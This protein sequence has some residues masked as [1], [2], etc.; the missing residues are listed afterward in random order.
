MVFGALSSHIRRLLIARGFADGGVRAVGEALGLPEWRAK[1]IYNQ[2]RTYRHEE[3]TYAVQVLV[4]AD[5][6]MKGG[7]LSPEVALERAVLKIVSPRASAS[8]F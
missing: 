4:E 6:E 2:A 1:R 7:D 8:L 5:L 3:L